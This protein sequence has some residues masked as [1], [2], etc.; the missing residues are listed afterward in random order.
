MNTLLTDSYSELLQSGNTCQPT[1]LSG[2]WGVGGQ[3]GPQSPETVRR[4]GKKLVPLHVPVG[5]DTPSSQLIAP[6]SIGEHQAMQGPVLDHSGHF[7][8]ASTWFQAREQVEKTKQN[9][10]FSPITGS[11]YVLGVK[12]PY[13]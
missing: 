9:T 8:D 12:E 7:T 3:E 4:K 11:T 2:A 6:H 1:T 5:P 13:S 10:F